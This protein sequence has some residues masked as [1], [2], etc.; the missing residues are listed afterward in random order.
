MSFLKYVLIKSILESI[1]NNLNQQNNKT[2]PSIK[3]LS[4]I[5][6]YPIINSFI[7][8]LP[9]IQKTVNPILPIQTHKTLTY[10]LQVQ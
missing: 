7:P 10:I 4:S 6:H 1:M 9:P 2:Q 5:I 3:N 8:V